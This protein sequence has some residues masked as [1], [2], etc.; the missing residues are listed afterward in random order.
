MYYFKHTRCR[1]A[2]CI[3]GVLIL[4]RLDAKTEFDGVLSAE[5]VLP[6]LKSRDIFY[7][8]LR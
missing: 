6:L 3:L 4:V 7:G 1:A 2:I 5:D 8:L